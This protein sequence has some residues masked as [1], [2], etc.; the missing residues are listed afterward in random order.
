MIRTDDGDDDDSDSSYGGDVDDDNDGVV[1]DSGVG[2]VVVDDDDYEEHHI[3]YVNKCHYIIQC[4]NSLFSIFK[5][6]LL[7]IYHLIHFV[8]INMLIL[9]E[10][11]KTTFIVFYL[12][13][14][15]VHQKNIYVSKLIVVSYYQICLF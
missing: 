4:D 6:Y 10:G 13:S 12:Q 8:Q 15:H 1:D 9:Q 2:D 11:I 5:V 3:I 7:L 14:M